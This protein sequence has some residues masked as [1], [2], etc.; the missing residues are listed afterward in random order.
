MREIRTRANNDAATFLRFA[1]ERIEENVDQPGDGS[2][3]FV[4]DKQ[5]AGSRHERD[6]ALCFER[7]P[8]F[9]SDA[10][11]I[12]C[13]DSDAKDVPKERVHTGR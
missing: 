2:A 3:C 4:A 13:D 10:T 5:V 8:I 1:E 9:N 6:R 7:R 11:A 12:R